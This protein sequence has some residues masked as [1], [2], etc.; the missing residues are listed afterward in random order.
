LFDN[1]LAVELPGKPHR[2]LRAAYPPVEVLA[3]GIGCAGALADR[4]ERIEKR[5]K[6]NRIAYPSTYAHH[7]LQEGITEYAS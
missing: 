3:N 6:A 4:I 2:W 5:Q 1:C 7:Q